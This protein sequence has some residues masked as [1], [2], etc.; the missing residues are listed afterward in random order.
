[1]DELAPYC[2]KRV[3]L[4]GAFDKLLMMERDKRF[5]CLMQDCTAETSD[6]RKIF[7]GHKWRRIEKRAGCFRLQLFSYAPCRRSDCIELLCCYAAIAKVL[8]LLDCRS[9]PFV[10]QQVQ[11]E[12]TSR[13]SKQS[14]FSVASSGGTKLNYIA[15]IG[16]GQPFLFSQVR[17]SFPGKKSP[18]TP[19]LTCS[20]D[21][22]RMIQKLPASTVK[23]GEMV[24]VD[25]D[26][27]N[28]AWAVYTAIST[29]ATKL[30]ILTIGLRKERGSTDF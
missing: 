11:D 1:M 23:H 12:A 6:G 19:A 15:R 20:P 10:S 26:N 22:P 8:T 21:V 9:T 5:V 24:V 13:A 14:H 29:A 25:D 16:G 4:S 17:Y 2:D 7:V 30:G 18:T 3:I 27:R 28:R